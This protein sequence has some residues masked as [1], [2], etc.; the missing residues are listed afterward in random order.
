MWS[1]ASRELLTFPDTGMFCRFLLRLQ[2]NLGSSVIPRGQW[3]PLK[4]HAS[5]LEQKAWCFAAGEL[6]LSTWPQCLKWF[7][8]KKLEWVMQVLL[9]QQI[10]TAGRSMKKQW[11]KLFS[12]RFCPEGSGW[13]PVRSFWQR[14]HS[15][16]ILILL[17]SVSLS[18]SGVATVK[19]R[20]ESNVVTS[21]TFMTYLIVSKQF[22]SLSGVC[23]HDVAV[24]LCP[25]ID[26]VFF[27]FCNFVQKDVLFRFFSHGIQLSSSYEWVTSPASLLNHTHCREEQYNCLRE[28][29]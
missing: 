13:E 9:W 20:T 11:V 17:I 12:S 7:L 18:F 6:M 27:S 4:A 15:E 3:S 19:A 2:R 22:S 29:S 5:V 10:M 14:S 8:Q 16:L 26:L 28:E 21:L 1:S 24:S 23:M 25:I